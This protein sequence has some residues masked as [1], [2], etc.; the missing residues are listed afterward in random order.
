MCDAD[1]ALLSDSIH[2]AYTVSRV[3][4][5]W[6]NQW[7]LPSVATLRSMSKLMTASAGLNSYLGLDSRYLESGQ[8]KRMNIQK[9]P[10]L[11]I[12]MKPPQAELTYPDRFKGLLC[13]AKASIK[14][15]PTSTEKT[16]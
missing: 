6:T 11:H 15:Y 8:R 7:G 10:I 16:C 14:K 12:R 4:D 2:C 1:A 3:T 9:S 5:R 13:T